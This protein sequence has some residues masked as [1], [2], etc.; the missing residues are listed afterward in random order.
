MHI[1]SCTHTRGLDPYSPSF[2]SVNYS[3]KKASIR[4]FKGE[5]ESHLMLD[6]FD[7]RSCCHHYHHHHHH[8]HRCQRNVFHRRFVGAPLF[9]VGFESVIGRLGNAATRAQ[10]AALGQTHQTLQGWVGRVDGCV[11]VDSLIASITLAMILG[12]PYLTLTLTHPHY[13]PSLSC[14]SSLREMG[15][16]HHEDMLV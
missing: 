6:S 4:Y 7:L 2:K 16:S 11:L 9:P 8:H 3:C 1:Q 15:E 12:L 14:V 13:P 5:N 10:T